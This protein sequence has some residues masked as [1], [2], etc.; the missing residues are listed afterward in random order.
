MFDKEKTKLLM[1]ASALFMGILGVA[2][3]F[4]PQEILGYFNVPSQ[5]VAVVVMKLLGGL[6]LAFAFLNWM[7]RANLIG[8]IYSRPVAAGNFLN[9]MVASITLLKE[10]MSTPFAATVWSLALI[11]VLF[12][13]IFGYLLFGDGPACKGS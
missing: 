5:G 9:F 3:S 8:G 7:A 12:A 6:Y 11:N 10:S 13:V 4:F 2:I 1:I